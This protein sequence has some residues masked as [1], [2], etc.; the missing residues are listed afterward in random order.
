MGNNNE[1]LRTGVDKMDTLE[2]TV[3]QTALRINAIIEDHV[4]KDRSGDPKLEKAF[5]D[6]LNLA[7]HIMTNEADAARRLAR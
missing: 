3:E 6:G 7:R 4:R 5:I 1:I 2:Y